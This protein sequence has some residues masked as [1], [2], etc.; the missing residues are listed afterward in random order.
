MKKSDSKA[1]VRRFKYKKP[2]KDE[3]LPEFWS[4]SANEKTTKKDNLL[5]NVWSIRKNVAAVPTKMSQKNTDNFPAAMIKQPS[6]SSNNY[7]RHHT[8]FANSTPKSESKVT[9]K[10][11]LGQNQS[12]NNRNHLKTMET[13][14]SHHN[15]NIMR[16]GKTENNK[17]CTSSQDDEFD[18]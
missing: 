1:E 13:R 7:S 10:H 8:N 4:D 15:Q 14:S 11:Q 5:E 3:S 17:K 12:L 18:F 6:I 2:S 16:Y 9:S